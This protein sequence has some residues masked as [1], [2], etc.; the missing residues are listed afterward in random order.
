M[1]VLSESEILSSKEDLE[2]WCYPFLQKQ[3]SMF[4]SAPPKSMKS[5][6]AVQ[7]MTAISRGLPFMGWPTEA[8]KVFYV[9]QE[10][11]IPPLRKRLWALPDIQLPPVRPLS[12][13]TSDGKRLSLD[14]GTVGREQLHGHIKEIRP[15]IVVF[16]SL[17]KITGNDENSSAEMTKMFESLKM[18]QDEFKF[19]AVFVH[20]TRKVSETTRREVGMPESMRGSGELFA[21]GDAYGIFQMKSETD[22]DVHWTFRN[23]GGIDPFQLRFNATSQDSGY[24][25]KRPP[26]TM[27]APG[28][29]G[30][31]LMEGVRDDI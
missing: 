26:E 24:L 15:Q 23:H 10:M 31:K 20:H 16:D 28:G 17:R 9:D 14:S 25:I 1:P 27:K 7:M 4:L 19:A 21:H 5:I 11:G 29:K 12:F 8:A 13:F 3:G 2:Y 30:N 22:L 18:L 6:F